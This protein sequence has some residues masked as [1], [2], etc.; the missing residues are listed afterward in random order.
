MIMDWMDDLAR[1]I[2]GLR[3]HRLEKVEIRTG[4]LHKL[5]EAISRHVD[6]VPCK[7]TSMTFMD[8]PV[9]ENNYLPAN[10]AVILSNGE[11]INIIN[12]A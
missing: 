9:V 7:S 6:L 8:V 1:E 2:Q 5:T 12:F 11:I 4:S 10:T 3:E